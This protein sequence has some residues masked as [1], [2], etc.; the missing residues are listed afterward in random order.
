MTD[1]N[2]SHIIW[3]S[4][5]AIVKKPLNEK[6]FYFVGDA[7]N[8]NPVDKAN[9]EFFGYRVEYLPKPSS[10]SRTED[11]TSSLNSLLSSQTRRA[12]YSRCR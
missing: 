8:G 2:V 1:G 10:S 5:T 12:D 6:S 3:V 4:D 9:V 7:L 11:T